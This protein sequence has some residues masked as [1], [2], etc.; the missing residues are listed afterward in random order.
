MLGSCLYSKALTHNLKYSILY[1]NVIRY[2]YNFSARPNTVRW[3]LSYEIRIVFAA[4]KCGNI[5]ANF[6]FGVF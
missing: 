1:C 2:R 5:F 4:S 3:N 6:T